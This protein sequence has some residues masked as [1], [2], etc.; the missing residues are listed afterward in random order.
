MLWRHLINTLHDRTTIPHIKPL[1]LTLPFPFPSHIHLRTHP[2]ISEGRRYF[3]QRRLAHNSFRAHPPGLL[4]NKLVVYAQQ[5]Q[6]H[7]RQQHTNKQAA[8]GPK[9]QAAAVVRAPRLQQGTRAG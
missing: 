3:P 6:S 8:Q 4:L 1:T 2:R 5:D 9:Y 7:N